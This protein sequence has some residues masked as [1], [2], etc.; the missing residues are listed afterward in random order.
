MRLKP[1][2]FALLVLFPALAIAHAS[3]GLSDRQQRIRQALRQDTGEDTTGPARLPPLKCE[4]NDYSIKE[5]GKK[6][7]VHNAEEL[8][9]AMKGAK[10]GDVI[11]LGAGN[12]GW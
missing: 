11:I 10:G 8:I 3:E 4:K 6:T 7:T 5:S 9:N 1:A 2:A 12:Y